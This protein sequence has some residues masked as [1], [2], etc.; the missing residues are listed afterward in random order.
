[1]DA[2]ANLPHVIRPLTSSDSEAYRQLR[3]AGFREAS[4]AFCQ[5]FEDEQSLPAE[6][7][8]SCIGDEPEHVTFGAFD[9]EKLVGIATLK[10]DKRS[11]ARH[12]GFIHTMYVAPE[13]RRR[14]LAEAMLAA[15]IERARAM[16]G[17][18][19]L[20]L[21]VLNPETSGARPL[22][23]KLGFLAQGPV[24]RDD[25]VI[26]GKYVDAEYMVLRL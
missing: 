9:G 6:Y 18:E 13:A 23:L 15:A 10:R 7:F 21:W 12:K 17:L 24:V 16:P 20:H 22:Y 5:S 3:L 11:K 2:A 4:H 19:Q 14:G 8:K 26:D 1:M 25:L